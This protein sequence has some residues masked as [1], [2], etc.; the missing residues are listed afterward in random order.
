M[1][2]VRDVDLGGADY[3]SKELNK[4]FGI[5][6]NYALIGLKDHRQQ[7]ENLYRLG[8]DYRAKYGKKST[9]EQT[10]S[11]LATIGIQRSG[12]FS[13]DFENPLSANGLYT[14]CYFGRY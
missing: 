5:T 9:Q 7:R 4:K 11:Y 12:N 1:C 13:G 10:L 14:D 3:I 2:V 8:L 6:N